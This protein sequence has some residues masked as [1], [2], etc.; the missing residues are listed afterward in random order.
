MLLKVFIFQDLGLIVKG[1]GGP[2]GLWFFFFFFLGVGFCKIC[3]RLVR[4]R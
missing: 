1:V 4:G 3:K 2:V